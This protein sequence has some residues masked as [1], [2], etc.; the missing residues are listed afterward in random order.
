[1]TTTLNGYADVIIGIGQQQ[2]GILHLHHIN[3]YVATSAKPMNKPL[4]S[5]FTGLSVIDA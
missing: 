1:L 5:P 3:K 2:S 4:I